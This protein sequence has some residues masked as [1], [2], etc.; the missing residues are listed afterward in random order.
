LPGLNIVGCGVIASDLSMI[1]GRIF[2]FL[3]IGLYDFKVF[4]PQKAF[5]KR[6][7]DFLIR[8][9]SVEIEE[10]YVLS[11]NNN[12]FLSFVIFSIY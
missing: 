3:D 9:E 11:K 5:V 10:I 12:I 2:D 4:G 1:K 8:N 7:V 6:N